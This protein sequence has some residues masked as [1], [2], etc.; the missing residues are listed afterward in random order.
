[1]LTVITTTKLRAGAE[2]QWDDAIN[3][4]FE[5]AQGRPG[6]ISGQLL[7]PVDEPHV[8]VIVGTWRS[9]DDWKSW[10]ED[11]AFLEQRDSLEA[12]ASGPSEMVW[13][14]VVAEATAG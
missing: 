6:W 9:R 8:R 1:M 13:H 2:D 10:H 14:E 5:S 7:T 11:P 3:Q 4:R 12:V